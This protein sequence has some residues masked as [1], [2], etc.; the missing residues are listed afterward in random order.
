MLRF[1]ALK[2]LSTYK[3]VRL[4]QNIIT[5]I[6]FKAIAS[7]AIFAKYLQVY[8]YPK[9]A[10]ELRRLYPVWAQAWIC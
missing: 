4:L 1:E 9:N 3:T 8:G 10:D 5:K 7:L 2:M 6:K